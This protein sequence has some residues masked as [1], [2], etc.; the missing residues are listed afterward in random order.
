[1]FV[2]MY[3][4]LEWLDVSVF[5][6]VG[7]ISGLIE[8]LLMIYVCSC[9]DCNG[10]SVLCYCYFIALVLDVSVLCY[11]YCFATSLQMFQ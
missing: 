10:L 9:C 5:G 7:C 4:C 3:Q 2:Y 11:C 8:S 6:V 1:M